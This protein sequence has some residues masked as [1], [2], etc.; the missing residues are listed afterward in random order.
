[1]ESPRTIQRR[2]STLSAFCEFLIIKNV[3]IKNPCK[4]VKRPFVSRDVMTPDFSNEEVKAIL[5]A[6]SN[7]NIVGALHLAI[8]TTL[9]YTGLRQGELCNL[10]VENLI[11]VIGDFNLKCMGKGGKERIV[12][13]SKK[14]TEALG[15]YLKMRKVFRG[16]YKVNDYLF[17]SMRKMQE[18]ENDKLNESSLRYILRR[19]CKKAGIK[20]PYSVHSTRAT[21]IGAS[22][23]KEIPLY[24]VSIMAGHKDEAL[25]RS[26]SK[27]RD[28]SHLGERIEEIYD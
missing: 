5:G 11:K 12:P 24:Q 22:L 3:L 25:T 9:F 7:H 14:S 16:D 8:L 17:V 6:I 20:H 4:E 23:E 15:L 19:Y 10:K 13:L 18:S 26:Y 21:F 2:L 28:I 27:R 1:M